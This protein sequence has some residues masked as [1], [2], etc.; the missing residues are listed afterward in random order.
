MNLRSKSNQHIKFTYGA[1]RKLI[2]ANSLG[3]I[4]TRRRDT[5][6]KEICVTESVLKDIFADFI[7]V[8]F[9][10]KIAKLT[11]TNFFC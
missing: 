10:T 8:N 6:R 9:F 11:S 5:L 3:G 2:C 4:S 1:G 7:F